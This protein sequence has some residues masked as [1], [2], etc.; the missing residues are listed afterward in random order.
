LDSYSKV[1]RQIAKKSHDL[2]SN[3]PIVDI[4]YYGL[5]EN[6]ENVPIGECFSDGTLNTGSQISLRRLKVSHREVITKY[7]TLCN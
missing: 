7:Q 2:L 1:F 4:I 3:N 6:K 5:T